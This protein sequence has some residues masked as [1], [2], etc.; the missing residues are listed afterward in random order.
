MTFHEF[1]ENS[2]NRSSHFW[3]WENIKEFWRIH[4]FHWFVTMGPPK[5]TSMYSW[6]K[7][8]LSFK[9][10]PQITN[11]NSGTALQLFWREHFL[12]VS[13]V[14]NQSCPFGSLIVIRIPIRNRKAIMLRN[15]G[16]RLPI[17]VPIW[18][19]NCYKRF[20]CR[21]YVSGV[22]LWI[23]A[24]ELFFLKSDPDDTPS[25]WNFMKFMKIHEIQ[26][27]ISNFRRILKNSD[28]SMDFTDLTPCDLQ[29]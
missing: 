29:K 6:Y 19:L 24:I 28:E 4:G 27:S 3:L 14:Q 5:I 23:G 25:Q 2:W 16:L 7:S 10:V 8:L 12:N 11:W 17:R 9:V 26:I 15:Q 13:K 21:Y 18:Q 20:S 1:H 22:C